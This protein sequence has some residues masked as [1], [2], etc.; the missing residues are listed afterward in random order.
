MPGPREQEMSAHE[1]HK[2]VLKMSINALD[3]AGPSTYAG[4]LPPGWDVRLMD[5]RSLSV[6][7]PGYAGHTK[8]VYRRDDKRSELAV[9]DRQGQ[10]KPLVIRNYAGGA[11]GYEFPGLVLVD[12][13]LVTHARQLSMVAAA[14]G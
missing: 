3:Q 12:N 7:L 14:R 4:Q 2:A 8:L 1:M 9:E 13:G 6:E 11:D 10:A 5:S